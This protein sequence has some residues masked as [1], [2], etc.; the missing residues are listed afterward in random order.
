MSRYEALEKPFQPDWQG[1]VD[2]I[3][4]KGTPNRVFFCE[5]FQDKEIKQA[6]S[7]RYDLPKGIDP[8]DPHYER[9]K[10]IA[11]QR[12]CGYDY[13][14]AGLTGTLLDID[15]IIATE[16]TAELAEGHDR[17]FVDPHRGSILSWEDFERYQWPD[18]D[19]PAATEELEWY[20][21]NLPE[22]M[23][24]I[25]GLT[26]HFLEEITFLMGYEN[27]CF[28]LFDQRDLVKAIADRLTAHYERCVE[29]IL[30]YDRV[31][32]VW[33][34]DDMGFKTGLA[35]SPD[36][37]R[38]YVLPSHKLLAQ[39]CHDK[40]RLYLLHACGKLDDI[41]EDLIEDVRID[42]KHSFEDA[43]VDICELKQKIGHRVALL[44]GVDVD[45][46]CRSDEDSIRERV[47]NT[48]DACQEGG[49]YC[50]GT[51]NSVAN[52]I[53]LDNYLAMLDEGRRYA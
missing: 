50:L 34:T 17:N 45:F 6:I 2:T 23:C 32:M 47:R 4:R 15:N 3:Q 53:P 36:D 48:L 46:L 14:V 42:A 11:V 25:G 12:F 35:I 31:K 19:A 20:Q 24:I 26:G 39:M 44:G 29:R 43:I 5:I 10:Y 38:E 7:E 41:M 51:G 37:I 49:G 22:D 9:W 40:D 16:D 8:S 27:L 28:A 52:Y 18:V 30:E 21:E 1:F 33:G 13:V